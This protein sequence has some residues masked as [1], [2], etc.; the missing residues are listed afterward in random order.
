MKGTRYSRLSVATVCVV[1]QSSMCVPASPSPVIMVLQLKKPSRN[2]IR[3][4]GARV[5]IPAPPTD[6]QHATCS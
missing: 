2:N 6:M 1:R 5:L 3:Y 4:P